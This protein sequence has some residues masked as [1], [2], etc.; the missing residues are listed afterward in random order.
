ML[1]YFVVDLY[2]VIIYKMLLVS[3]VSLAYSHIV[4]FNH[5]FLLCAVIFNQLVLLFSFETASY[6]DSDLK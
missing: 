1:V 2:L 3:N 6:E 4:Y 5:S